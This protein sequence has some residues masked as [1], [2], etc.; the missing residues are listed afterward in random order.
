MGVWWWIGWVDWMDGFSW[1]AAGLLDCWV[2]R[3]L[4]L[5]WVERSTRKE[6]SK[7]DRKVRR[8]TSGVGK[9]S[10]WILLCLCVFVFLWF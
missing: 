7:G 8:H 4:V 9:R 3:N 6:G 1:L 2:G 5:G 10:R